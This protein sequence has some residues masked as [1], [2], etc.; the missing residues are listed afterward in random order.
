MT[1]NEDYNKVMCSDLDWL[2]NG[3]LNGIEIDPK[4]TDAINLI[5]S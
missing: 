4:Y 3:D 2:V 5:Y 1:D